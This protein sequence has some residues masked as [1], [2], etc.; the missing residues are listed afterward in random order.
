M[1]TNYSKTEDCQ[2]QLYSI[3]TEERLETVNLPSSEIM[4]NCC[5]DWADNTARAPEEPT[6]N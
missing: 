1:K 2:E 4:E 3:E 5:T 6:I